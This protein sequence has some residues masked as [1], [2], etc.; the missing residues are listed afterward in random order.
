VAAIQAAQATIPAQFHRSYSRLIIGGLC[1][2]QPL[3]RSWARYRTRLFSPA[4]PRP[5]AAIRKDSLASQ[6]G[7]GPEV[8][9]WDEAGRDRVDLLKVVVGRLE[10]D[11][12]SKVLDSGWCDWDLEVYSHPW[13]AVQVCTTQEDHGGGRK[14]FRVRARRRLRGHAK[15]LAVVGVLIGIPFMTIHPAIELGVTAVVLGFL[16]VAWWDAR[17]AVRG[18]LATVDAAARKFNVLRCEP[19]AGE[20]VIPETTRAAPKTDPLIR[21]NESLRPT[22]RAVASPT[23]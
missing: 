5:M 10:E 19:A 20:K 2:A 15:L 3:Y 14:L 11:R 8:A 1:Y 13:V 23:G 7:G 12:W 16:A 6:T 9:Y 18:V 4:R 21:S 17:R 22:V